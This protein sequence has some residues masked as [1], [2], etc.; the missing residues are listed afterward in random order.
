MRLVN[1]AVAAVLALSCGATAAEE[2]DMSASSAQARSGTVYQKPSRGMSMQGVLRHFGQPLRKLPAVGHPPITRWVYPNYTVYF[3]RN[4][5]VHS[6]DQRGERA[7]AA[8]EAPGKP[9]RLTDM[10]AG[11]APRS[12]PPAGSKPARLT[13]MP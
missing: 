11:S 6:V 3:E 13:D 5:V 4:L 7:T 9:A 8:V 10:P 12:A 2:L 1:L